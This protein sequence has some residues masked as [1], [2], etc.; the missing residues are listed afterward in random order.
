[1]RSKLFVPGSRPA[2]FSKALA[3]AADGVSFDLEDAVAAAGKGEARAA[4][5]AFLSSLQPS[6]KVVVV[7]V[8]G[9]ASEHHEADL[10]AL[11]GVALDIINLPKV[12]HPDQVRELAERLRRWP[13]PVRILATIESPKGLR[14]AADIACADPLLMGLQLGFADLFEP[15]G[16]ERYQ[17]T[18]VLP[19]QLAVRLAAAEAGIHAYDAAWAAIQDAEGFRQEAEQ[20]RR[21]GFT[22]KSCIHPSQVAAANLAFQPSEAQI[23]R[24]QRVLAAAEQAEREGVGAYQVDGHMVDGPF[25]ASARAVIE[26]AR[27]AGLLPA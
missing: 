26:Q 20:A 14:L 7:R 8:N 22:G 21:L 2:L 9:Q 19:V 23:A 6:G 24:A 13:R 17:P 25:V 5:G 15:L 1:M 12:E 16:I 4:L 27:S 18:V 3:S 10:E 11:A